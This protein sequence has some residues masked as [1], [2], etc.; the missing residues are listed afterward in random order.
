MKKNSGDWGLPYGEKGSKLFCRPLIPMLISFAGGILAAHETPFRS[1][2]SLLALLFVL[3]ICLILILFLSLRV[4]IYFLLLIFFLC[5]AVLGQGKAPG[6]RLIPLAEN[7]EKAIIEGTV[8]EPIKIING[9][10][11]RLKLHV[12]ALFLPG[13]T[14]PVNE[15]IAVTVYSNIPGLEAGEKIRFPARFRVFRNFN[16]PGNYD[17][18]EAMRLQGLTCAASVSDGRRIVPMGPGDLPF[19]RCMVERVQKPVRELFSKQLDPRNYALFRALI[20]G[21]RQGIDPGLREQFNQTGLGHLLAVSGLHIGLVAWVAFFL[22]KWVLSRSYRLMLFVDVRRLSAILTCLPVIGYTLLAGFQVSSQRAMIMVLAFLGSMIFGRERDIWSTFAL[23][24]L[25]IL[26]LDPNALFS[27]SFQLSFMAVIGIL[28]LTPAILNKI[29][30]PGNELHERK[31]ILNRL[32]DY[33]VGLAAVSAAAV[34]F[35]LPITCY[36]FHRISLVSIPANLTT[37]PILG[38]WVL[39]LGLLSAVTVPFSAA[40]AGFFLHL[41]AWGLNG[42]ME[43]IGFWSRLPWSSIW[44]VTPNLFE[45]LIFYAFIFVIFFFKRWRWAKIGFAIVAVLILSDIAY[46]VHRVRFNKDL[47]VTFLDVRKGNAALIS[48]PGGKK[49]IIDGGGFPSTDFDVGKMVVAPYLWNSKIRRVDYMVLSH[50]QADHM[51]GLRFIA[52]VFHPK[53]FWSNGDRAET[54]AFSDLMAVIETGKIKKMLPVD[55]KNGIKING[56]EV[57][58]LHPDPHGRSLILEKGAKWLNNNSLVLKISYERKSFLF[59]GDLEQPGEEVL[60]SNAGEMVKSDVLLS[61]H[62]GSKTSSSEGFLKMVRPE[63]CIISSG[64]GS[65]RNFPHQTV[66]DRLRDMG[67]KVIRI[68][69]SGAVTVTVGPD[70]FEVKTFLK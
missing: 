3:A 56:A 44:M 21:E 40:V 18:K 38:M 37:V 42:M 61:P 46:W 26:F 9:E 63:I 51:N 66:L 29:H 22:F 43:V 35:L 49:M 25:V 65:F 52:E 36:Y 45:I 4:K 34:L 55:L 10:I 19:P 62:H 57:R 33:F 2:A 15:D 60:V 64:E 58:I 39:P 16:N 11:A 69:S 32:L 24:G 20:L 17:Y 31:P 47:E 41:G 48:F 12:T 14:I 1:D 50:P 67:C 68:S 54:E 53:E 7:R 13:K 23:A 28:W 8:L 30:Y 70:R 5:G 6:S 59:L 27:I